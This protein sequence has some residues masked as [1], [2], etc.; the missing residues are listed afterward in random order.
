VSRTDK[1]TPVWVGARWEPWHWGCEHDTQNRPTVPPRCCD[2]PATPPQHW[3]GRRRFGHGLPLC[4]WMR[5]WVRTRR[6]PARWLVRDVVYG[7]QRRRLRDQARQVV[8]EHRATG[9]DDV[10]VIMDTAQHRHSASWLWD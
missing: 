6:T 10:D 1:D 7:P 8:A 5:P 3:P 2:L 4:E 9:D